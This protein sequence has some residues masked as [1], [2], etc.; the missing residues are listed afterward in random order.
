MI[1]PSLR[2]YHCHLKVL[3]EARIYEFI[4]DKARTYFIT[5]TTYD[6]PE[7]PLQ[8]NGVVLGLG[9]LDPTARDNGRD[10]R[11]EATMIAVVEQELAQ[12]PAAIIVWVCSPDKKQQ[13]AR[14]Q[15]F[16]RW[17]KHYKETNGSLTIIKKDVETNPGEYTSLLYRADHPER[18]ELE[19]LLLGDLDKL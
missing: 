7:P 12:N 4:D 19:D 15:L 14:H 10:I 11:L 2:P 6:F 8:A 1:L 13:R 3:P 16:N 17:H 18:Q 5:F 9:L